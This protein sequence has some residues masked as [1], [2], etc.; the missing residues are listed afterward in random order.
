[1]NRWSVVPYQGEQVTVVPLDVAETGVIDLIGTTPGPA[2]MASVDLGDVVVWV[3]FA[4]PRRLVGIESTRTGSP[5]DDP[6]LVSLLGDEPA[7]G[8]E[9]VLRDAPNRSA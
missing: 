4:V 6:M 1:M 9:T 2:G 8:R 5:A 3:D 7:L